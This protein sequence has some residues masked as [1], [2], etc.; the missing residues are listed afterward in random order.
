M[1]IREILKES[2]AEEKIVA[3]EAA[4]E[5]M[6]NESVETKVASLTEDLKKKYDTVSEEYCKKM[7]VEG[8]KAEKEKLIAEYD[9]KFLQLEETTTKNLDRF[10]DEV[11]VPQVTNDT[12]KTIAINETFAPIVTGMKKLLE[13]NHIAI[14]SEG[15][16]ILKEARTEIINL[17]E[18]ASQAI[19]GKLL[20]EERLEKLCSH[21]FLVEHTEGLS[22]DLKKR[23]SEIFKDKSFDEIESKLPGFVTFLIESAKAPEGDGKGKKLLKEN[24]AGESPAPEA[25]QPIK[26]DEKM[27]DAEQVVAVADKYMY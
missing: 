21:M 10:L 27:G 18:Q 20:S 24:V 5:K 16:A 25:K 3:V 23:A 2:M 12:I 19:A 14:D 8:V 9:A 7:I 17:K 26:E 11:V 15:E 4:V 22:V 6:I 1:G 13:E